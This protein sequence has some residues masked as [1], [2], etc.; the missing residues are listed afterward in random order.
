MTKS[1]AWMALIALAGILG[2]ASFCAPYYLSDQGNTFF[3]NFVTHELLSVLGVIVTITL[4]SAA[5]LH[6]E[7]NKLRDRTEEEFEEARVAI[8][9]SSY[10]LI[11]A[12][13]LAGLLVMIKPVLLDT[14]TV[15][16]LINSAVIIIMIF[17]V[18]VLADLTAAV[19]DI[20]PLKELRKRDDDP[21]GGAGAGKT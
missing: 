2:A 10:S 3:K 13:V 4:A 16:A 17:S 12:F 5:N 20:P 8:R 9:L 19:F 18:G 7:I 15:S 21:Q 1:I 11:G 6:L 14:P